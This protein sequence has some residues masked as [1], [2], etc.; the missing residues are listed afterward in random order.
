MTAI[1]GRM[2]VFSILNW[3]KIIFSYHPLKISN[4]ISVIWRKL[5][6]HPQS[7]RFWFCYAFVGKTNFKKGKNVYFQITKSSYLLSLWVSGIPK[8][9]IQEFKDTADT[10]YSSMFRYEFDGVHVIYL[11]NACLS[12]KQF[13]IYLYSN[14]T[15]FSERL[16]GFQHLWQFKTLTTP[17]PKQTDSDHVVWDD[18]GAWMIIPGW[19]QHTSHFSENIIMINHRAT[20]PQKFPPVTIDCSMHCRWDMCFCLDFKQ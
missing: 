14:T 3:R 9:G 8:S 6:F 4:L 10:L 20:Q 1:I 5:I 15:T 18:D 19:Q 16:E 13:F 12:M 11:T 7:G 2:V 17:F